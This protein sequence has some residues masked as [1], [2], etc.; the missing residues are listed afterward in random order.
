MFPLLPF[1]ADFV[2]NA[3]RVVAGTGPGTGIVT[4]LEH[5][6]HVAI[7]GDQPVEVGLPATVAFTAEEWA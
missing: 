3:L 7:V 4:A 1:F 2:E 6:D 5:P